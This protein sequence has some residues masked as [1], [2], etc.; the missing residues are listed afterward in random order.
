MPVATTTR[1]CI[2]L[3]GVNTLVGGAWLYV[4]SPPFAPSTEAPDPAYSSAPE[5]DACW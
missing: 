4:F 5:A 1:E 3:P 2:P